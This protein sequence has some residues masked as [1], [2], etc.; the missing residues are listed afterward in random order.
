MGAR[1]AAPGRPTKEPARSD[2]WARPRGAWSPWSPRRPGPGPRPPPAGRV[3]AGRILPG[4]V[5]A[6]AQRSQ[7]EPAAPSACIRRTAPTS[8]SRGSAFD[9][10]RPP[11]RRGRHGTGSAEDPLGRGCQ[12][13]SAA[14]ACVRRGWPGRPRGHIPATGSDGPGSPRTPSAFPFAR[15]HR[16]KG[17]APGWRPGVLARFLVPKW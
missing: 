17:E 16:A 13:G 12:A 4:P 1:L 3:K 2:R 8:A 9:L 14:R 7:G 11:G 5:P 15:L 6:E 10:R